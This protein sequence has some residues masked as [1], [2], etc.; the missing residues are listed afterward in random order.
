VTLPY[1]GVTG[2]SFVLCFSFFFNHFK[3]ILLK[4]YLINSKIQAYNKK[5][6]KIKIFVDVLINNLKN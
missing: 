4:N 5:D 3:K 1:T 2:R 6:F